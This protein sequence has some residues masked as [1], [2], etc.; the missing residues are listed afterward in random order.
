MKRAS[1]NFSRSSSVIKFPLLY[2]GLLEYC[3]TSV[4]SGPD[5]ELSSGISCTVVPG[6]PVDDNSGV[7]S[8]VS[9]LVSTAALVGGGVELFESE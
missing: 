7:D 4:M 6:V 3:L 9:R 2:V 1:D 5:D 8:V